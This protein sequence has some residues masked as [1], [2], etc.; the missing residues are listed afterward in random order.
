MGRHCAAAWQFSMVFEHDLPE[1]RSFAFP[2]RAFD[3][4]MGIG[5]D[6]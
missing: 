2:D 4:Q 6:D 3:F 1:N 5:N